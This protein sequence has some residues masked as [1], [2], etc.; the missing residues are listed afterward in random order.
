MHN[1]SSFLDTGSLGMLGRKSFQKENLE[2]PDG[3][4]LFLLKKL[5]AG[6]GG[7]KERIDGVAELS[8]HC[9]RETGK[10]FLVQI[11]YDFASQDKVSGF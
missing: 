8:K 4:T 5:R 9:R 3:N 2:T 11:T 10:L 6:V 7:G 1:L